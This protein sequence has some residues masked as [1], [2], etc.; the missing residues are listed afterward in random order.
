VALGGAPAVMTAGVL[1][2]RGFTYALEI[3]VGGVWLGGWLLMRRR[4]R[5]A[6]KLLVPAGTGD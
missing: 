5:S 3:P 1:L 4:E 6:E 2:Y